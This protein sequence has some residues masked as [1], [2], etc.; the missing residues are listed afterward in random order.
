METFNNTLV[1]GIVAGKAF[2][3]V[4]YVSG[5]GKRSTMTLC[6]VGR[7][8]Y[9]DLLKQSLELLNTGQFNELEGYTAEDCIAAVN[10]LQ[11]GY[12]R[13]LNTD[14]PPALR[15][16]KE[17]IAPV[18]ESFGNVA[19]L[20]RDGV[21]LPDHLVVQ[22]MKVIV[23]LEELT[24]AELLAE[25]PKLASKTAKQYISEMLPDYSYM[26]RINLYPGKYGDIILPEPD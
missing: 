21:E 25:Q 12:V 18:A 24:K 6:I 10:E 23:R 22:R 5:T 14:I 15:V 1:A 8:G 2:K 9:I 11:T 4:D 20:V 26:H 17:V 7:Q 3:V 13:R 19:F 16:S